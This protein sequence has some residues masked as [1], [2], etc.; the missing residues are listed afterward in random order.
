MAYL[1]MDMIADDQ[2]GVLR[3][4]YEKAYTLSSVTSGDW[5]LIPV[6]IVSVQFSVSFTGGAEGN[7]SVT[8]SIRSLVKSG[9]PVAVAWPY[10]DIAISKAV[11]MQP[12]TAIRANQTVAGTMTISVR[13]Q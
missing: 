8:N 3:C 4:A 6:N 2:S 5:I 7:V 9:S 10:G 11:S 1:E 13:A 12:V